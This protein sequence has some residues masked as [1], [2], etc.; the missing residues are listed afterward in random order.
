M[1]VVGESSERAAPKKLAK[2]LIV[3]SGIEFSKRAAARKQL[4][5]LE[6]ISFALPEFAVGRN[7]LRHP[8]TGRF[9]FIDE[10]RRN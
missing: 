2:P 7:S 9:G 8:C 5:E 3:V 6:A 1:S 4:L 10:R